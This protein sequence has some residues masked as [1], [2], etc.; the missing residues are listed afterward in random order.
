M[1]DSYFLGRYFMLDVFRLL[2]LALF[3]PQSLPQQREGEEE[4]E[5]LWCNLVLPIKLF[6]NFTI[7]GTTSLYGEL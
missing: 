4:M 2:A 3:C 1:L 6:L 5:S 7:W